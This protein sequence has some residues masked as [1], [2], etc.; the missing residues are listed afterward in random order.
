VH[1]C[2]G[3][4]NIFAGLLRVTIISS[5]SCRSS[6]C[7]QYNPYITHLNLCDRVSCMVRPLGII[8]RS[9]GS[10][11]SQR[12]TELQWRSLGSCFSQRQTELQLRSLGSCGLCS[13]FYDYKEPVLCRVFWCHTQRTCVVQ[14]FLMSYT[15]NL[16]CAGF[17]D[18]I[19]KEPVLWRVFWCHTQRTCVVQGFLM[20][21]TLHLQVS[22]RT[23]QSVLL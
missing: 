7:Q 12:Q 5:N 4:T 8:Q 15:K 19:H 18:V 11:F 16:C 6:W 17:S 23:F 10:C 13:G 14:G 2:H 1:I 3:P 21:Y 20:S 22:P 9:L